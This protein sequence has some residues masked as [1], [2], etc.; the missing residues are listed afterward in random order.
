MVSMLFSS[1]VDNEFEIR[2]C[3]NKD[4]TIGICCFS[5]KHEV[6]RSKKKDC[7]DPDQDD[8]SNLSD[9]F[10]HGLLF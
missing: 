6:I 1:Q 5:A 10:I 9:M 4:N 8:A 7:L 3:Q 2:S